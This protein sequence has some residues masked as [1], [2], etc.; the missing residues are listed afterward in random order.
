MGKIYL[1]FSKLENLKKISDFAG[2]LTRLGFL[3]LAAVLTYRLR[4]EYPSNGS[5]E[6]Y[7]IRWAL[8]NASA[9]FACVFIALSFSIFAFLIEFATSGYR[10]WHI[11]SSTWKRILFFLILIW[12][13]LMGSTTAITI[14]YALARNTLSVII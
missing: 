7:L 12:L 11:Q 2:A 13:I 14:I 5:F 10:D 1:Y 8:F 9:V 6:S 3:A 4:D